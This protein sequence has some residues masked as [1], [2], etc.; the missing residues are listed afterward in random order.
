M[1]KAKAGD[2]EGKTGVKKS[3]DKKVE[4]LKKPTGAFRLSYNIGDQVFLSPELADEIIKSGFG[5]TI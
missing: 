4:F 3:K 2:E 5:K 1:A